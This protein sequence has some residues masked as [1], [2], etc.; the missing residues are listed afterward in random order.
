MKTHYFRLLIGVLTLSAM[1]AAGQD[2]SRPTRLTFDPAQEGFP[3]WDP[4]GR[5]LVYFV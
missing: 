2:H 1:S 4:D 5:S 3:S